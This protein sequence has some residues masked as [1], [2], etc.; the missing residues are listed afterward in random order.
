MEI[1]RGKSRASL[2]VAQH[3]TRTNRVPTE[4][5]TARDVLIM[6]LFLE[7]HVS[8]VPLGRRH[9]LSLLHTVSIMHSL[10]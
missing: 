1:V 4:K 2:E 5:R 6:L 9:T 7:S 3:E 10:F 8:F